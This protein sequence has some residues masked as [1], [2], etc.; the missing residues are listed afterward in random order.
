MAYT[1][2]QPW[3]EPIVPLGVRVFGTTEARRLHQRPFVL[4]LHRLATL[5]VTP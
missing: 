2:S 4:Y 5:P 3:T 1:S